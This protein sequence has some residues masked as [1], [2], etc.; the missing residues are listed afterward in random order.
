MEFTQS[1]YN[2]DQWHLSTHIKSHHADFASSAH[3]QSLLPLSL[4]WWQKSNL[5]RV[6]SKLPARKCLKEQQNSARSVAGKGLA[7][8]TACPECSSGIWLTDW[9]IRVTPRI[10]GMAESA[11]GLGYQPSELQS[12][13][14]L[15]PWP[16]PWWKKNMEWSGFWR[17]S[18][19]F[20]RHHH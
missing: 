3:C 13:I 15:H 16:M 14:V 5:K 4:P 10:Q 1:I 17:R 19:S 6:V 20:Y 2:R 11:A 18:L 8:P 12:W 9:K 7:H